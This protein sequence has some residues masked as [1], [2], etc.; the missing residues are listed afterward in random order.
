MD[1]VALINEFTPQLIGSRID[2][3]YNLGKQEFVIRFKSKGEKKILAIKIGKWINLTNFQSNVPAV[4]SDFVMT[5]RKYIRN[6]RVN[7]LYQPDF[8]RIVI[9]EVERNEK[10]QLILEFFGKGNLILADNKKKIIL[11]YITGAW[12][13]REINI[14]EVY[15][16]PPSK[17]NILD[18]NFDEFSKATKLSGK[19]LVRVLASDFNLGGSWSEEIC[20]RAGL[21]KNSDPKDL[22]QNEIIKVYNIIIHLIKKL[23]NGELEPAVIFQ[24]GNGDGVFDVIPV[25]FERYKTEEYQIKSKQTF[26]EACDVFWE[27]GEKEV[28]QKTENEVKKEK[29]I[30]VLSN[31]IEIREHLKQEKETIKKKGDFLFIN[32]SQCSSALTKGRK[33]QAD[34]VKINVKMDRI[35]TELVLDPLKSIEE[36]AENY[37][38]QAKEIQHKLEGVENAIS[39]VKSR[40]LKLS[41]KVENEK[42]HE[43]LKRAVSKKWFEKYRWFISSSG[44]LVIAGKDIQTNDK[45][46]RKHLKEEDKYIHANIWGAPS[47][48]LKAADPWEKKVGIT[49]QALKETCQF[50]ASYSRAWQNFSTIEAYWVNPFQVSKKTDTGEYMPKGSW[51]ILG[52]KNMMR[53]KLEI[54]VG[55]IKLDNEPRLMAGPKEA[56]QKLA[57]R[58]VVMQ[59]GSKKREEVVRELASE[60]GWEPDEVQKLIPPGT[61]KIKAK[62]GMD[63]VKNENPE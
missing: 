5:L 30:K 38:M 57:R 21:E 12:K 22:A 44:N 4:P 29:L 37:Y 39:D 61:V 50:A 43:E 28:R 48:I 55:E 17:L 31:Q 8:E 49:D 20:K 15:L 25:T 56:V 58:Y 62:V 32:Y 16:P 35:D 24:R 33:E 59:P 53:V 45:I 63:K 6:A 1:F 51:F 47:C 40:I 52:K 18:I 27:T 10:Y 19:D 41:K 54:A 26:N 13:N 11:A 23:Q 7:N 14:G 2:Q 60:F 9:F 34:K 36:N 46:V 42:K 3:I